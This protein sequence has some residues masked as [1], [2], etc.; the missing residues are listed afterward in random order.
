MSWTPPSALPESTTLGVT[1]IDRYEDPRVVASTITVT[2]FVPMPSAA[3]PG[4]VLD[5]NAKS[6]DQV[7]PE[8]AIMGDGGRTRAFIG[9]DQRP[10]T[11]LDLALQKIEA[12]IPKNPD[13]TRDLD[14]VAEWLRTHVN[15]LIKWAPG[16][17]LNDGQASLPWDKKITVPD[18]IWTT[19]GEAGDDPVGHA[20][21]STEVAFPVVPFERWLER[22]Q[23]YCIHKALLA[24]LVLERQGFGCKMVNGAVA[25]GPGT[26]TGHTWLELP[27]GRIFDPAWSRLAKPSAEVDPMFPRRFKFGSSWRFANEAFPYVGW[28][29]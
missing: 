6:F 3:F 1:T 26:T 9:I 21:L 23:G 15:S 18:S 5:L 4:Q 24:A 13:G 25:K 17:A 16:S 27:D 20:P 8:R 11:P 28:A 29:T 12:K 19:F 7:L 14:T 22:G 10:G 2:V